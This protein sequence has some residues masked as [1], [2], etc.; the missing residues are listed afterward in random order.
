MVNSKARLGY[1]RVVFGG[2]AI[3]IKDVEKV[4]KLS[5]NVTT[6]CELVTLREE[7]GEREEERERE[8]EREREIY[9]HSSTRTPYLWY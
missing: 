2:D 9:L 1:I 7:R 3:E 6:H 4:V 8:R 5:M